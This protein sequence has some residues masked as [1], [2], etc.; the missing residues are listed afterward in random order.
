MSDR[1]EHATEKLH[2]AFGVGECAI[3][4]RE[5]LR[6]QYD[7]REFRRLSQEQ[8]LHD[9]KIGLDETAIQCR[10]AR[11]HMQRVH[12]A[13]GHL[14]RGQTFRF[15]LRATQTMIGQ[16]SEIERAGRIVVRIQ[17]D[18]T[19]VR[20][21]DVSGD[22]QQGRDARRDRAIVLLREHRFA[23]VQDQ[24][25]RRFS[26]CARRVANRVRV[27]T[28]QLGA[29]LNRVGCERFLERVEICNSRAD[30]LYV[31]EILVNDRAHHSQQESG[32]ATIAID[33]RLLG[34]FC[35]FRQPSVR[36]DQIRAE[37][38]RAAREA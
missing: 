11:H 27:H 30:E 36:D 10:I 22:E 4:F 17:R 32:L 34:V 9:E 21:T 23:T 12:L 5:R 8:I 37:R 6:G 19:I 38:A 35:K 29:S 26:E 31:F 13:R 2:A 33:D 14:A 28:A 15:D 25:I 1:L 20:A 7:I 16:K 3:A 24:R 18:Q